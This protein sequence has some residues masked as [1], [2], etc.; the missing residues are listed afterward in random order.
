M[1][2]QLALPGSTAAL[3]ALPMPPSPGGT[4]EISQQLALPV[5]SEQEAGEYR[6][7]VS[8]PSF[9]DAVDQVDAGVLLCMEVEGISRSGT[10]R[11]DPTKAGAQIPGI[12]AVAPEP[13]CKAAKIAKLPK[14]GE[15]NTDMAWA[16]LHDKLHDQDKKHRDR[17][18]EAR[19]FPGLREFVRS[20]ELHDQTNQWE[21]AFENVHEK[22]DN[23]DRRAKLL[24]YRAE[25]TKEDL[26]VMFPII[27]RMQWTKWPAYELFIHTIARDMPMWH[28][29]MNFARPTKFQRC[30]LHLLFLAVALL[31]ST[32]M[33]TFEV[34]DKED[35]T[36]LDV[37]F[38]TLIGQVFS[39]P[40]DGNALWVALFADLIARV[41][42]RLC[43]R[44]FF[45][46]SLARNKRPPMTED[47]RIGQL[48]LWHQMADFGKWVC[49]IGTV[50]CVAG[51]VVLCS[52]FP[53]PRA[54]NV[55]RALLLGMLWA[56]VMHP[57]LKGLFATMVLDVARQSPV[58]DGLL[59]MFPD[60]MDFAATGVHTP[61]FLAWRVEK[62]VSEMELMR[63]LHKEPPEIGGSANPGDESDE[64]D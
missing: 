19:S 13:T 35:V 54:A 57:F 14:W 1:P 61:Q 63:R 36:A 15:D 49:G 38:W 34:V 17:H 53:Q 50:I 64:E 6:D 22:L 30:T 7:D 62:I 26:R 18:R 28:M 60:I 48:I 59:T 56:Y 29:F 4:A 44:V 43:G 55:V 52:Q 10:P 8:E 31:G 51:A 3:L 11:G 25:C 2:Q 20:H 12:I 21:R 40:F 16:A 32:L 5:S 47:A 39:L 24:G 27:Q 46:Y 45:G 41:V 23:V 58:F 33:L 42:E 9:G 37:P